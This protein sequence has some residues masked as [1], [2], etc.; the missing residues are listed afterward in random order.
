MVFAFAMV[1]IRVMVFARVMGFA[2]VMVLTCDGWGHGS[3]GPTGK[4]E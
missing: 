1:L 3:H 2:C 4:K